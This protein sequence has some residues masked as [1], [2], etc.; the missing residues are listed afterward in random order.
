[1]VSAAIETDHDKQCCKKL[2]H[3]KSTKSDRAYL[4]LVVVVV[5][6]VVVVVVF[7]DFVLFLTVRTGCVVLAVSHPKFPFIASPCRLACSLTL[8]LSSKF[9]EVVLGNNSLSAILSDSSAD[10]LLKRKRV[11]ESTT[12]KQC[13]ARPSKSFLVISIAADYEKTLILSDN[14]SSCMYTVQ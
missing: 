10:T 3:I 11:M 5:A 9:V 6:S 7:L 2:K 12:K 8:L 4:L 1:M 13:M 14:C